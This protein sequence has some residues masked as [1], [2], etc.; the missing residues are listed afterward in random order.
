[1]RAVRLANPKSIT[2]SDRGGEN[3]S[4]HPRPQIYATYTREWYIDAVN[5]HTKQTKAFDDLSQSSRKLLTRI[6]AQK[7]VETLE[8][9]VEDRIGIDPKDLQ[10]AP[11]W[12]KVD[13]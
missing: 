9:L 5:F 11:T 10:S 3:V 7:Y 13:L 8:Q 1:M 6:D 2:I 12:R 4:P